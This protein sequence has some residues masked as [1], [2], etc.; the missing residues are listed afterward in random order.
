M[1][2]L[3]PE[4]AMDEVKTQLVGL[5]SRGYSWPELQR[6]FKQIITPNVAQC[7]DADLAEAEKLAGGPLGGSVDQRVVH[8]VTSFPVPWIRSKILAFLRLLVQRVAR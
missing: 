3:R 5:L 4:L 6:E 1:S 8:G 2:L 7:A